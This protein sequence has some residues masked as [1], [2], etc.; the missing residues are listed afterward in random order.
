MPILVRVDIP[1]EQADYLFLI[2]GSGAHYKHRIAAADTLGIEV[3]LLV[4]HK[5][6][7]NRTPDTLVI[8]VVVEARVFCATRL[9]EDL[10]SITYPP[11]VGP[12][13]QSAFP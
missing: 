5:Q 2:A 3:A 1:L 8:A 4:G 7:L 9:R 13:T 12:R 11:E 6:A 10:A